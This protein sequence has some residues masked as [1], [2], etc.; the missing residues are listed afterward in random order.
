MS[1]LLG[2]SFAWHYFSQ[3]SGCRHTPCQGHLV[4]GL[5]PNTGTWIVSP[6]WLS[7]TSLLR[8]F[9]TIYSFVF[10]VKICPNFVPKYTN[11]DYLYAW[12]QQ[13]TWIMMWLSFESV[14]TSYIQHI[15]QA[16]ADRQ[17]LT[18][19]HWKGSAP[20]EGERGTL[21]DHAP[22]LSYW[23]HPYS[24]LT[25]VRTSTSAVFCFVTCEFDLIF[26]LG[27]YLT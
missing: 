25:Y 27:F 19:W 14:F 10:E 17:A 20:A 7:L 11:V 2:L 13:E 5:V 23:G 9:W 18:E 3:L 22:T 8:V 6:E 1:S 12:E 21:L 4:Q 15:R 16:Q 24:L 26:F